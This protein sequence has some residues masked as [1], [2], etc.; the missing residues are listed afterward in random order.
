MRDLVVFVA[1]LTMEKA[2]E[3]FLTRPDFHRAHNLN[4]RPFAFDPGMDL[5]RIPGNDA[6]VFTKGHE[7]VREFGGGHRHAVLVF[8]REYGTDADAAVLRDDLCARVCATGWDADRFCV[9]VIDPELEAWIWQR[10]QRVATPLKFE[11]VPAMVAAVRA[12]GLEWTDEQPKPR[13]PKEALQAVLR[14]R[15]LGWSAAIHRS[16][17][18]SVSLVGC[19]DPAFIQLRSALQAWFP[20]ESGA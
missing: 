20:C 18:A 8:D 16:I 13:R 14:Q 12:A 5:I 10:N 2:I 4:V 7:W 6:G 1:D 19:Q 11:S 15:G 3:A 17:T 9:V